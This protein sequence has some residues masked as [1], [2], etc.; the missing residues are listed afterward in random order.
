M[1]NYIVIRT[2]LQAQIARR[3]VEL[4]HVG[5]P[6]SVVRIYQYSKDE[7][8]KGAYPAYELLEGSATNVASINQA[9]GFWSNV[10]STLRIFLTSSLTGGQVYLGSVN[11]YW[12]AT[13]LQICPW[14][15]I[16]TF[17]DGSAN[18]E[19]REN[20]YKSKQAL[21]GDTL[22]RQLARLV[23]PFGASAFVIT[24]ITRHY[25]IYK[26]K[27]NIV[28]AEKLSFIEMDWLSLLEQR[29]VDTLPADVKVILLGTVYKE[30]FKDAVPTDLIMR[31]RSSVDL[32][33]PH[34][35]E[36]S[37]DCVGASATAEAIIEYYARR[38][39]VTV[40]HFGSSTYATFE[41]DERVSF[42]DIQNSLSAAEFQLQTGEIRSCVK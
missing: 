39:H 13:A 16:F 26:N 23:F 10:Y 33:I 31:L 14:Q 29:V 19:V 42:I 3:L 35:R 18:F 37:D 2:K 28:G 36:N 22:K 32:Y 11:L 6:F 34:P 24:R 5:R 1:M 4:G 40:L 15:T 8:A 17:D 38:N 7:D 12:F 20:S 41:G 30:V 9:D 27:T 25:T 21:P